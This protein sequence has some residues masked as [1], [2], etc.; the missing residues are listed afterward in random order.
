[1]HLVDSTGRIYTDSCECGHLVRHSTKEGN[2]VCGRC[3]KAWL[4][5]DRDILKG[6]VQTSPRKGG[7]EL[8]HSRW[9]D[10]GTQLHH[11]LVDSL[12][13]MPARVFVAHSM[14]FGIAVI[15]A[16]NSVAL[17]R[18][19]G[20]V[21]WS[22]RTVYRYKEDGRSEWTRRLLVAGIPFDQ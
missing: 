4:Y 8:R 22:E 1:M 5:V 14:G 19:P 15:A 17:W 9:I 7:F 2:W 10:V 20:V 11:F 21:G 6:E 18:M 3:G 16:N 12:W 13:A